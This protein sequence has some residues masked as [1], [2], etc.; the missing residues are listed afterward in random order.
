[1]LVCAAPRD[2]LASA[3]PGTLSLRPASLPDFAPH[4]SRAD[5]LELLVGALEPKP[6][7]RARLRRHAIA[8]VG[9]M[10][11]AAMISLGLLRRTQ[12]WH[13]TAAAADQAAAAVLR[14]VGGSPSALNLEVAHLRQVV[15]PQAH[16][17]PSTDAALAMGSLLASWPA[18]VPSKPQSIAI[19]AS[20]IAVSV[21]VEGDANRFLEAFRPPAGW[22]L[23]EPR[24]NTAGAVTRLNL[25][26]RPV[27][28]VRP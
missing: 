25:Q 2:A 10:A 24:L 13:Q 16:A 21:T 27:E 22:T 23:E 9:I 14:E 26:L 20:G 15:H 12:Q 6:L 7:R 5:D 3:D 18:Q 19:N 17:E 8:L 4:A 28:R 1:V 11:C